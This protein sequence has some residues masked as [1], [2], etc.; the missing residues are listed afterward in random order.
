MTPYLLWY[1]QYPGQGLQLLLRYYSGDTVVHGLSG[2]EAEFSKHESY[3]HAEESLCAPEQF[4]CV[5]LCSGF[6]VF[7]AA[8]ETEHEHPRQ[9]SLFGTWKDLIQLPLHNSV[10]ATTSS[11][12]LCLRSSLLIFKII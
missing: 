7:G 10:P 5:L 8:G 4:G 9:R 1:V 12:W 3:F 2:F 11:V 6:T